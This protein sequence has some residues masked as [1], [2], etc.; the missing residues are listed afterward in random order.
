MSV[1]DDERARRRDLGGL[2]DAELLAAALEDGRAFA[3]FYRRHGRR[4]F[5]FFRVRC[6]EPQDAF[7]LV[8]ETFAEVLDCLERFDP[9]RGE[10]TAWLFGIAR[11]KA[12]RFARRGRVDLSAR[13]RVGVRREVLS[14]DDLEK[15]DAEVDL[16]GA[17]IELEEALHGLSGPVRAAVTLRFVEDRPYPAVAET[18]RITEATAR[19]RVSRGLSQLADQLGSNPFEVDDH[20]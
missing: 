3:E 4:L 14:A 5:A 13:R 7:D 16:R 17:R 15:I 12:R 20:E 19:K 1:G 9:D 6:A 18:L 11:N 8:S 2:S 10:A